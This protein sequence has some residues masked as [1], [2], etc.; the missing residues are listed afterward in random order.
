MGPTQEGLPSATIVLQIARTWM[1]DLGRIRFRNEAGK[2]IW[3]VEFAPVT[4]ERRRVRTAGVSGHRDRAGG[5]DRVCDR[6]AG[7]AQLWQYNFTLPKCR[8]GRFLAQTE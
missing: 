7:A 2:A 5:G 6:R 4:G 8:E 1:R 3:R